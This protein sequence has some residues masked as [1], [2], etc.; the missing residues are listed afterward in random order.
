MADSE[1]PAPSEGFVVTH[2]LVSADVAADP[3]VASAFLNIT[4]T[5][6]KSAKRQLS[7]RRNAAGYHPWMSRNSRTGSM[8]VISMSGRRIAAK[9]S[10]DIR[11]CSCSPASPRRSP[12]TGPVSA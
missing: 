5:S 4:D 10:A 6:S 3:Q 1:F 8:P 2:F 7:W 11:K 12:R 9:C